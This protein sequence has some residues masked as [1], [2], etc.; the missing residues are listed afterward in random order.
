MPKVSGLPTT[1]SPA[2]RRSRAAM[3]AALMRSNRG[4]NRVSHGAFRLWHCLNDYVNPKTM[5]CWPGHRTIQQDI[6]CSSDSVKKWKQELVD[7]G[8]LKIEPRGRNGQ[9]FTLLDG[10]KVLPVSGT[11]TVPESRNTAE[12][13]Q[14][15]ER[16]VPESRSEAFLKVGAEVSPPKGGHKRK[17]EKGSRS[18]KSNRTEGQT[19]VAPALVKQ[20]NGLPSFVNDGNAGGDDAR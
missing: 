17:K 13:S 8:W 5:Q 14:N 3:F 1:S 18:E 6:V 19:F 4:D 7:A 12:C 10:S 20:G 2:S 9:L 11:L 16:S 15:Q